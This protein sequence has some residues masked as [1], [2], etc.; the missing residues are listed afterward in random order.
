MDFILLIFCHQLIAFYLSFFYLIIYLTFMSFLKFIDMCFLFHDFFDISMNH[1]PAIF[2]YFYL[3]QLMNCQIMRSAMKR[4]KGFELRSNPFNLLNII[5]RYPLEWI[6]MDEFF[7]LSDWSR[8]SDNNG[9]NSQNDIS[10]SWQLNFNWVKFS[11]L[12]SNMYWW[13]R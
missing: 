3:P 8:I 1:N 9:W 5:E 6:L 13:S 7:R 4:L 2:Y 10:I 12:E 11:K